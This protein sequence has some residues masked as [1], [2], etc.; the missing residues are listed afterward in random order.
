MH[1]IHKTTI[2]PVMHVFMDTVVH[3]D[4]KPTKLPVTYSIVYYFFMS[5]PILKS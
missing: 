5:F 4:T 2:V 3:V 1:V